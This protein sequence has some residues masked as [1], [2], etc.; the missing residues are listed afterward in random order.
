M[1]NLVE[2]LGEYSPKKFFAGEFPVVRE[3]GTAGEAISQYDL[4]MLAGADAAR[5]D[6]ATASVPGPGVQT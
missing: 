5:M 4:I 6:A 3:I 1:A 2:K